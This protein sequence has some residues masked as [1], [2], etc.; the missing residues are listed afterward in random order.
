MK[1]SDPNAPLRRQVRLLGDLLGETLKAQ[2]G[3]ALYHK[4]ES[5]RRLSKEAEKGVANALTDLECILHSLTSVEMLNVVRA[6]S[7][8]LNLA[9]IAEN[10]HRIRRTHWYQRHYQFSPQPGSLEATFALLKEKKIAPPLILQAVCA[11]KID[12]VLTAH[13]TEV[14]RRTLMQK[15]D[16]IAN[17]LSQYDEKKLTP[18]E[19]LILKESLSREM[20]AIWQ[21]DEIRRRRPTPIDEAKWGFAVIE[22]SLWSALPQFVRNLDELLKLHTGHPLPLLAAPLRF[23]SWMG[24][25]RDGNPNVT[26]LVTETVCLM[27]RWV[28]ADLYG[29]EVDALSGSLSMQCCSPEMAA[30]V[31]NVAEP[32]RAILRPLKKKLHSTRRWIE[33]KLAGKHNSTI[34]VIKGSQ[35]ILGPLILC[36][37]SLVACKAQSVAQGE[38]LDLI[39]R[40]ACFGVTLLPLDIR[41]DASKH[42]QLLDEITVF[43]ELGSYLSWN[44]NERQSFLE[45]Q[46][47]GKRPLIPK[48]LP[49]SPASLEVWNTFQVLGRQ[50][51]SSL[52]AY[53]ISMAKVP[54]DVLAVCL[55]QKEAGIQPFLRVVPLF[56]TLKDLTGAGQCFESLLACSW[57]RAFIQ[58]KQE[59]MIG[60]SDPV[61]DAGII[62]ATWA[63]YQAQESLHKVAKMHGVQL[64][65]FHGRGGSI[66]R[67]G[68]P[69]HM[70]ILSQPPGCIEGCLRVTEQGEVIRNKYGLPQ[71]ACRS[72]ALYTTATLQ[73]MLLP[74]PQPKKQWRETMHFLATQS[75]Q[76]YAEIVKDKAE[77]VDYFQHVTPVS[78]IGSLSI[79]SRPNRRGSKEGG[80]ESLRAIPWVFAWTQNRLLLPAWL[81]VGQALTAAISDPTY[82]PILKEMTQQWPFFGSLLSM[83]EMVLTKADPWLSSFYEKRLAP[84]QLFG[85]GTKLRQNF[86]QTCKSLLGVLGTDE[87]LASN[88]ILLR[89]ILLRAPYLYP[90]HLLQAELIW[91]V[92]HE[93]KDEQESEIQ[94]DALMVSISGIAAGM[95]NTG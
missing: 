30:Q 83:I 31:G 15:F 11:L 8:F 89:T 17:N 34:D 87:L 91:R 45:Q 60:Y 2:V 19:S 79:G 54:S 13:P 52:G 27:A 57:Y 72:L 82:L 94:R 76:A 35:E 41:Q 12:L 59:I 46:L 4:I 71:R 77:F 10:V 40:V 66:G 84:A 75:Y 42:T 67:G 39:R 16:R 56:E 36:Y 48:E 22:G 51:P 85:L 86:D 78:E 21:T 33:N 61:K 14:M 5:I 73:A 32:Y 7:H 28:A 55:L 70:A 29:R 3:D 44:E 64:T 74:P 1:N 53:V 20:T 92:R 80:L 58:N 6:F 81:G 65:L 18:Q 49:L 47:Q 88:P 25:D 37:E 95:Q 50:L 69:A 43:L 23:S 24:G 63:Q 9:N 68:A 62:A 38:L 90:L 26:A 93:I